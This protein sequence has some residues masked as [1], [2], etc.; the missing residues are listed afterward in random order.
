MKIAI[1]PRRVHHVISTL[2]LVCLLAM[3]GIAQGNANKLFNSTGIAGTAYDQPSKPYIKRSR[4]VT[5]NL[6][7]LK[8]ANPARIANTGQTGNQTP[9][10]QDMAATVA[11]TQPLLLNLFPDVELSV[12]FTALEG[13]MSGSMTWT[14]KVE[15]VDKSLVILIVRDGIMTG[16]ISVGNAQY[17]VRHLGDNVHVVHEIKQ[18]GYPS[19]AD[20][21]KVDYPPAGPS[22]DTS[23]PT[24]DASVAKDSTVYD[25][26]ETKR[27]IDV[28]VVY[29]AAA[30]TA[31]GGTAAMESLIDLAVAETNTGYNNS[32]INQMLNLVHTEE[33]SYTESGNIQT[34]RDRL[35]N[36]SDGFM[37]NVHTLRE[38]YS[39]DVVPLIVDNGGGYCGIAFI[40][41]PVSAQFQ[42]SAFC[43]VADECATGYYSFGHEIGHI[44]A[45]RHDWYVD[46][47]D[48]SPYTY[49]HALTNPTAGWRTVMA[50]NN[51]CT[52][53][54]GDCTRLL[55]W[56]NPDNTYES[57][58]MGVREGSIQP[59]DNRKTLANTGFVVAN[60]RAKKSTATASQEFPSGAIANNGFN[61]IMFDVK[62]KQTTTIHGFATDFGSTG[63]AS[64][65]EI[66]YRVGSYAGNDNNPAA[67]KLAGSVNNITTKISPA[68]THIPIDLD[69]TIPQGQTYS[70]YLTTPTDGT[71]RYQNG[72]TE[73]AVFASDNAL[74]VME[75][76]GKSYP[77]SGG[78]APRVFTGTIYHSFH[79]EPSSL[80]I[81]SP[82]NMQ[83]G[84]MF[85]IKAKR[86]IDIRGFSTYIETGIAAQMEIWYRKGSHVGHETTA[87]DWTRLATVDNV[88]GTKTFGISSVEN[89]IPMELDLTIPAGKTYGFYITTTAFPIIEY[90]NGTSVGAVAASNADI[91]VLEGTGK[92]YPFST[93]YTPRVFT[94]TVYYKRSSFPW[95]MFM[96]GIISHVHE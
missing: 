47:T 72:T 76:K 83:N 80:Q 42:D 3:P 90:K 84:I 41:D 48:N 23:V 38:T 10:Q 16:N 40:M 82:N 85:D 5:L 58:P 12:T 9:N 24:S 63:T 36:P 21:D 53:V 17:Q 92:A 87:A 62:A 11:P 57:D 54:G 67:W 13:N 78:Y 50:Y 28:M 60:F 34:D 93:S 29:T 81:S 2:L 27:V 33:V 39:A 44:M 96:P 7:F 49:N 55:Y 46:A 70:F 6:E 22:S 75:G 74:E 15:G 52:D 69:I 65:V 32:G 18:S 31:Q 73:G 19:E 68:V 88:T 64:R 89:R 35:K 86:A 1:V 45:A 4:P 95:P 71:I 56:S 25:G 79:P 30:K 94:G 14:G 66:Y 91:A 26:R 20:P 43:V 59:A 8:A 77:F 37:D 51:A 61:G